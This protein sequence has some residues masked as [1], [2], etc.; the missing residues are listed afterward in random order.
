L[1]YGRYVAAQN[2]DALG[3]LL[4]RLGPVTSFLRA[5]LAGVLP[6]LGLLVW[7]ISTASVS[8]FHFTWI[9]ISSLVIVVVAMLVGTAF[10]VN[11]RDG[12][13][14]KTRRVL[15]PGQMR[16]DG[17]LR[18]DIEEPETEARLRRWA[19]A[20][21]TVAVMLTVLLSLLSWYGAQQAAETADWV[22][23]SHEVMT[24]LE[25][26][27]RHSLDVETGGRGFA[28]TG[29]VPFLQP[30]ESGRQAVVQDLHAL[31]LLLVTRD[32][33][34]RLNVLEGQTNNQV[35]DVEAIVA[36]RQNMGT[37]PTVALFEHGKHD[38]DAV[39]I[40]VEQMEVAER[41]LL[42]LRT[43]RAHA[44]QHSSIVVIALGS[45]LGVVF[46]SIA[47]MTVTREIGVGARA[48]ARV[49]ALNTGLEQRVEQR[50]AALEESEAKL[51]ASEQMFRTLLD[52]V[53]DYAVYMLDREGRVVTW[54]SGAARINGYKAE[55]IIGKHVS[56]FYVASD[57]ERNR[58]AEAL[59]Q[60]ATTGH[61]EEHGW[62]VRKDGSTFWANV[63]ITPLHD[64]DRGLSGY[65]K[66][67]RDVTEHKQAEDKLRSHAALLDQASDAIMVRDLENRVI[68]INKAAQHMYGLSTEEASG[69]VS[70]ELLQ[71]RFPV[72]LTAI[73][74]A[75][76]TKGDWE[77]ELRH[78]TRQGVEVV[79]ASRWT[80]QRDDQDAPTAILEINRDITE[81]KHAEEMR[82]RLAA[83]VDSSDDAI[84]S[85]T[86]DGTIAAWNRGAETV[87]G[88]SAAEIV[89][90]PMPLLLPPERVHEELDILARIRRGESIEHFET[91]RVRKDGTKIDVSVTISPIR[92][93]NGA[94]VGASK[95][96]RDITGRK[97]AEEALREKEQRL[98]ESQRI[99]H[100]G[101]WTFDPK[102]PI[103]RLIWS[104]EMYRMYGLSRD[105]F[106]P[107][108][109]ELLKRI[110]PEDRSAI[111]KWMT[112][113]AAGE[114]PGDVEFRLRLPDGTVRAFSRRGE[115]QYD[116]SNKPTRMVGTTQD[117]T[118][119][120][121]AEDALRE[122]EERF[123]T[124][125]NGIQ[126]LAWMADAD[127]SVFWY[128]QRWYDYTGITLEETRGWTWEKIHDP[129]FLPIVLDRW[130]EAIATG[131]P[132]DME[133]PLRGA[134]ASFHMFLT[135]VM[136]VR[137]SEG[138]VVR[139]LGTN[140]DISDR[141]KVEEQLAQSAVELARQAE[142]LALSR[143]D[144]EAQTSM[145]KL[146][147]ESMGEGLIAA[148]LEGHF[149][150]WNDAA[151]KLMGRGAIDLPTEQ[152]T[153][154]YKVFL[155]D[156]VTPCP[157]DSLPL[158]RA[159]RGESVKVELMIQP[160]DTEPG[161]FIEV[162]ARPLSDARGNLRGGVAVLHDITE[163]KRSAADLAQRAEELRH[164]RQ[165]LETQ[166]FMLQSVLDSM[167]E[168]LVAADEHG[169]FILWNPAAEKIM[170]LGATNRPSREWSAHYGLFLAD[171]V[172]P[173]PPGES[174]L[175]RT[176]R[177]EGG[178]TEVFLR[179]D[180]LDRG[181]WL[182]AIGSPLIDKD[183]VRRGGV[184]AFRDIT[185]R[186]TDE[187]EIRKLNEDLE[188][189]IA[190]RTEQLQATNHELEAFSYSVS[191][192]LRSPL[193]HI[194]GFSRILVNDFGP[195]M[196]VEARE[197]LQS[198]E[199]A[200]RRMGLLI[201][202]LLKMAVLRR[203]SLRLDHSELNPIVDEVISMLQPECQGRNVEWRIAKLP[204]LD[205]DPILMA[206]VFQN[207]LGNALKYSRGLANAVI[208]VDSIQQPDEPPIIFVRDN[209]AGFNMKYAERLFGVFQRFH[210]ES[211]FEGTGVGLATVH[212]IIQK[213][214]GTI[215]AEAEPDHGA[216]FYFSLPMTGQAVTTPK[217]T[218]AS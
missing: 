6:V 114:K 141:K 52:G 149:L 41:G 14:K 201:D 216:T 154:H 145:L 85:K 165:A 182:E 135:G 87:F 147:L 78:T 151:N 30:Y 179:H 9:V 191:H 22:A 65:S 138:R 196:T 166:T 49:K 153:P 16:L 209:G 172:T 200:V 95:I 161:K 174:P 105:T 119:R 122:S 137:N 176:L 2:L 143:G 202:A 186:K 108:L 91:V 183:G 103:G 94:I 34:Q 115:L 58:P 106:I 159:L 27:L 50:T 113:C 140:T 98:S 80:L 126:Q 101:S 55:E 92:D 210:T 169:K 100:I 23:H 129:A 7:L 204:A 211:E 181:L 121:Q 69:R 112:A 206:Q 38:M 54:N 130:K 177:G 56:C 116:S 120:R 81:Q 74:L 68:F 84:I 134:D 13:P 83:I 187:L 193:R 12:V 10:L 82:E 168:G 96:A 15:Q 164:S 215:W 73:E 199:D 99:A 188:G 37:I 124:M 125:A 173:I 1:V 29:S 26:A 28:E 40:T 136:P 20:A 48:R 88:Y 107:T 212:R 45:L 76:A 167:V 218:A 36:A 71:T 127:G 60:A 150:L 24:M 123:Q 163:Q 109:E 197:H 51:G 155:A 5:A 4:S 117:V 57:L 53:K 195:T 175:E 25:S 8:G 205:C 44:A 43:Q 146:V 46:L 180:G 11:R 156:G 70:H 86:L 102:D 3:G 148:D 72:Q 75:L 63:V 189:R 64:G 90:K 18:E 208:E 198:I 214:G 162:T 157:P 171:T 192:D 93:A 39:R 21:F 104:D 118:E 152:W 33:L 178:T 35:E 47:G 207:L 142:D 158:V 66:V 144:L 185:R 59:H 32:Q 17:P 131:T 62:R 133:F 170:G 77:G 217:A 139:W 110:I 194:A 89:G 213:H 79:V 132:L 184:L 61:F 67:V 19:K 203:Q 111:R 160:P 128:N 97:Q 31:R 190:K 42:A